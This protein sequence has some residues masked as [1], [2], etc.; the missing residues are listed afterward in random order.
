MLDA[1]EEALK[2]VCYF[3]NMSLCGL[4]TTDLLWVSVPWNTGCLAASSSSI[5]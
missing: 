5:C 1:L 4:S 3:S 2:L